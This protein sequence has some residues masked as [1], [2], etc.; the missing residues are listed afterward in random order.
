ME[1][2]LTTPLLLRLLNSGSNKFSFSNLFIKEPDFCS[3]LVTGITGLRCTNDIVYA[4]FD[5]IVKFL[6]IFMS[7]V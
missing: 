3:P 7:V 4:R 5:D 6:Y 2:R 1:P